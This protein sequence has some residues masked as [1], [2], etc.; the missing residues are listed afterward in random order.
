MK[1]LKKVYKTFMNGF[2]YI[3][4]LAV[5]GGV[6]LTLSQ[7]F[8]NTL[9]FN[10]G[11]TAIFL[12]Y[13]ILAGFIAF[14][15]SDRPGL[16]LGL[17]SGGMIAFMGGGFLS[18]SLAGFISGYIVVGFKYIF[19]KLPYGIKG[20]NPVFIYPVL[21]AIL[22]FFVIQGL[23]IVIFPTELWVAS[24]YQNIDKIYMIIIV[25]LLSYMMAYDLGG[26]INKCAYII[27]ILTILGGNDSYIMPAVMIAGMIPPLVIASSALLFKHKY[28]SDEYSLA[29]KNWLFGLSFITEGAL[30]FVH[31]DKKI[32]YV[33]I[34]ASMTAG[35]LS[36]HYEVTSLVA[37][38]GILSVFFIKNSFM[39]IFI[40]LGVTLIYGFVLGILLPK[41]TA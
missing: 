11:T 32:K 8:D 17:I 2:T 34:L 35:M 4:P 23:E 16:M 37:H 38:G 1:I 30:S 41:K 7:Q 27:G 13:P 26:P 40:L 24:S 33:L 28:N 21:G 29:K 14:A 10:F 9:L 18:A 6:F 12:I 5:V 3:I 19:N 20:L 22:M 15:I 25:G 39:F 36:V 31:K